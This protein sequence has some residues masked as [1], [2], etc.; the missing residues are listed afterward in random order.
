MLVAPRQ[1]P[2]S[3]TSVFQEGFF[4][5]VSGSSE[6]GEFASAF[7][8]G[9]K[10]ESGAAVTLPPIRCDLS[11]RR[12]CS[13]RLPTVAKRTSTLHKLVSRRG[14]QPCPWR[15]RLDA[16]AEGGKAPWPILTVESASAAGMYG[17]RWLR[18]KSEVGNLPPLLGLSIQLASPEMLFRSRQA[19]KCTQPLARELHFFFCPPFRWDDAHGFLRRSLLVWGGNFTYSSEE[20]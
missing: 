9:V 4:Q 10:S 12:R 16:T 2:G 19:T 11:D 15:L 20:N 5:E 14:S 6:S 7:P 1:L 3:R 17:A 8:M 13:A 18:P